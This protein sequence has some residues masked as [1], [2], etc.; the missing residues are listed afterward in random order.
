MIKLK[1]K[2]IRSKLLVALIVFLNTCKHQE[3]N[4]K[5]DGKYIRESTPCECNVKIKDKRCQC[6]HCLGEPG[7]KCYCGTGN[8]PC[9]CGTTSKG[10]KCDHCIGKEGHVKCDCTSK[11]NDIKTDTK[12]QPPDQTKK[13]YVRDA[14]SCDCAKSVKDKKCECNHCKGEPGAKCY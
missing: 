14:D 6:N 10:C 12:P 1:V 11:R 13:K 9:N 7:A 3:Q 8:P 4:T 5:D 2:S